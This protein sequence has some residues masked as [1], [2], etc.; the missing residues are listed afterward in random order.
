MIAGFTLLRLLAAALIPILHAEAYYWLWSQRFAW[1][2]F[3]HPPLV[4]VVIWVSALLDHSALGVRLGHVLL[5][6]LGALLFHRLSVQLVGPRA[7]LAGVVVIGFAP[8]WMPFG[9]VATPDGP[10]LF[11]WTAALLLFHVAWSGESSLGWLPVGLATGL[12]ILSKYNAFLLP[13]VFFAFLLLNARGRR[14]LLRPGPWLA[15]ALALLVAAPNLLWN[16][17]HGGETLTTPLRDGVEPEKALSNLGTLLALPL[18]MLTPLVAVAWVWQT[19]VGLRRGRLLGD[20]RFQ[21]L[22]CASWL[23]FA[24]FAVVSIL[25]EV[26]FH[27]IATCLVAAVPL[28]LEGLDRA[29]EDGPQP[30]FLRRSVVF[31]GALMATGALV[32]VMAMGIAGR[33][34]PGE[35]P[36]GLARLAFEVRGYE[37]LPE[38]IAEEVERQRG[39]APV[40]LASMNYHLVSDMEWRTRMRYPAWPVDRGRR[41]TYRYWQEESAYF[42]HDALYVDKYPMSRLDEGFL[43]ELFREVMPLDPIM[44]EIAGQPVKRFQ[45]YWCRDYQGTPADAP[46]D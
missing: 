17:D 29:Q 23:P 44:V 16:A 30:R 10:L 27:W 34:A 21:L 41:H 36:R 11:F 12:A 22:F 4:G 39:D 8:L 31:G 35:R 40:F 28:A 5:A 24:A 19:F 15:L 26:H 13:G 14:W 2:Y 32:V 43:R 3:D 33:Q 20:E 1:G 9:I 46:L 45:L 38:R 42:G 7:A 25:T 37:Q 6:S 18:A